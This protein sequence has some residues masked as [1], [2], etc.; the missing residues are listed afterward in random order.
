MKIL[1]VTSVKS[2]FLS[3]LTVGAIFVHA[4]AETES[5]QP[6]APPG[7]RPAI[8]APTETEWLAAEAASMTN[9]V[10]LTSRDR[11]VKAGE[12]YF[13]PDDRWIIFQAVEVPKAG[14]EPD[15]FYAMFVAPVKRDETGRNITSLGEPIR[16]SEPGTANTC[17]WFDPVRRGMVIF[18]STLTRPTDEKRSGFQVGSRKYV[19]MFP[20][21]MEIVQRAVLPL[22]EL[23]D[24]AGGYSSSADAALASLRRE[25][26]QLKLGAKVPSLVDAVTGGGAPGRIRA[27]VDAELI[28]LDL[29]RIEEIRAFDKP[30]TAVFA[31]PNYDAECSYSSDGRF[32]LY[33]H[34]EDAASDQPPGKPDANIYIYDTLTRATHAIVVAPGYD[35]GPFFSPDNKRICYRSDRK[36]ND[37]LQLY[38]GD[39]KFENGVPIGLA[40]EYQITDNE[41]VNWAPYF[42][43]SGE[44][45][46]Y[47]SSEVGHHNYEIFAVSLEQSV[48]DAASSA[49]TG[50]SSLINV[51]GLAT[52]RIT[53]AAGADVLPVYS[54][55]GRNLLW[56]SQRGPKAQGEERPS[57]QLWVASWVEGSQKK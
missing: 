54:F 2:T 17:G 26:D 33:T 44:F 27:G 11:F 4:A 22:L 36:G 31:S 37:L 8:P 24:G 45:L 41:A 52:R 12:A 28:D 7:S 46:V 49:A 47:G 16:V 5:H 32:I 13:S 29:K 39:L 14:T 57:S 21:E 53:H 50:E 10:Q 25:L 43:P 20:S 9:T 18:G 1:A 3:L 19:W 6:T 15:P 34:I 38:I 30:A 51:K 35:G 56:T 42:H 23:S 48:L 55:D 40:R